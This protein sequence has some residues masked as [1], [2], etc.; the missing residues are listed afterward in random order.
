MFWGRCRKIYGLFFITF[1]FLVL[2]WGWGRIAYL[3]WTLSYLRLCILMTLPVCLPVLSSVFSFTFFIFQSFS[4]RISS[5]FLPFPFS[6]GSFSPSSI[7]L[8][9]SLP[10]LPLLF[11][12]S[13]S[14]LLL[15]LLSLLQ[16]S[17]WQ[18]Q[19][20][21]ENFIAEKFQLV[22]KVYKS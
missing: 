10:S 12:P 16:S 20:G 21:K 5:L 18:D 19:Y 22:Y 17:N 1:C 14:L 9:S 6:I 4:Y 13:S 8:S 15:P 7:P 11:L 2:E 3:F